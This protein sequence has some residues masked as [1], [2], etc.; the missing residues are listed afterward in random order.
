MCLDS[1][2]ALVNDVKHVLYTRRIHEKN[3]HCLLLYKH[4][5]LC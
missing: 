3:I 5:I 2:A 4:L 1:F